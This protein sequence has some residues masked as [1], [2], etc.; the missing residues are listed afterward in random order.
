LSLIVANQYISQLSEQVREAVFGNAGTKVVFRVGAKDAEYLTEEFAPLVEGQDMVN[1]PNAT[2]YIKMLINGVNPPPFSMVTWDKSGKR[3]F[4]KYPEMKQKIIN[5][6]RDHY[7]RDRD[8][9]SA[10]IRTRGGFDK[11]KDEI[12]APAPPSF[13]KF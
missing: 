2:A 1:V 5:Y 11:K 12:K 3:D 9:V 8:V 13:P 7:G 4:P 6:S 10:E